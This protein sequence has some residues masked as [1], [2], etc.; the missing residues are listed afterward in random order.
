M[1]PV[2]EGPCPSRVDLRG[3]YLI[4]RILLMD[5]WAHGRPVREKLF[6]IRNLSQEPGI[7]LLLR[8]KFNSPVDP[9]DKH[10]ITPPPLQ[11]DNKWW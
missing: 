3:C 8:L 7:R 10:F 4:E 2:S 6:E 1:L 9:V 5:Y 11:R